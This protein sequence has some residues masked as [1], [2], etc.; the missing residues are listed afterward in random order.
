MNCVN[1]NVFCFCNELQ[2][3]YLRG[4]VDVCLSSQL[5]LECNVPKTLTEFDSWCIKD[6]TADSPQLLRTD[7]SFG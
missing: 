7:S 5:T 1:L 4:V 2:S 6:S 3:V